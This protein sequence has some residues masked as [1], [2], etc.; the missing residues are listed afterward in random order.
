MKYILT[1]S[2]SPDVATSE[3]D[4]FGK[5]KESLRRTKF[6]DD[7]ALIHTGPEFYHAGT[8]ALPGSKVA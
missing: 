1:R 2:Y 8:Q 7:N 3:F 4:L 5:L 6:D